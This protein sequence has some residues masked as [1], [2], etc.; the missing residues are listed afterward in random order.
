VVAASG[1]LLVLREPQASLWGEAAAAL[2]AHD[3]RA[4]LGWRLVPV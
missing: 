1:A 2:E 4:W 3:L